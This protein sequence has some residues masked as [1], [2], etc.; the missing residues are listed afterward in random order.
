MAIGSADRL[1]LR[2]LAKQLAD[3]AAL[4]VQRE[5]VRHWTALNGLK[6]V[7]PMV[8]IDQ[9]PWHELNVNDE[10]TLRCEDKGAQGI[11]RGFRRSIYRWKHMP[12]DFVV[13]PGFAFGRVIRGWDFGIRTEDDRAVSDPT[14][15][16][17]GHLYHDQIKT[18]DDLEKI[19][20]P[21]LRYDKEATAKG[22]EELKALFDG[23][24]DVREEYGSP[25]FNI[26]D[27]I[28]M[29]RGAENVLI[30]MGERPEFMHK[31]MARATRAYTAVLDQ[32]EDLGAMTGPQS[33]IHCTG[34]FSDELPA[35]GFTPGKARC[36]DMWTCGMSQI[37][38]SVSPAMHQEFELDYENPI[39]A[40]FGL[41]YFGCCEPLDKKLDIVKRIPNVRKISMSPWVDVEAAAEG[42]GRG[43]VFS[44]KPSP[45]F[46]ARDRWDP[47]AVEADL[48]QTLDACKRYGCPVE[49]ILKDIST[50]HYEPQ[51]LW[52]WAAIAAR[53]VRE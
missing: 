3:I 20:I 16:V 53:L 2:D 5:T 51:R 34:A 29:W 21:V 35:R 14:N 39:Y 10:L 48:R 37:F 7:R 24:M 13:E 40:R 30:D 41:V 15:D 42:I 31:L 11:E 9:I 1:V 36:K 32:V 26:W 22:I 8:M 25:M 19:K 18:E 23:V 33:W 27:A 52:E 6:P 46:L 17:V 50:V 38:G 12:A 49:L 44:R 28:V 45:A 47:A 43:Y 4:P